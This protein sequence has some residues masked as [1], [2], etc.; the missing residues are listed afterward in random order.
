VKGNVYFYQFPKPHTAASSAT[1]ATLEIRPNCVKHQ[2]Q[3][4]LCPP[5]KEVVFSKFKV[6]KYWVGS[7]DVLIL[8]KLAKNEGRNEFRNEVVHLFL[9]TQKKNINW[10]T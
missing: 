8:M 5:S 7:P 3:D 9:E 1:E 4:I 10:R 2:K 6:P